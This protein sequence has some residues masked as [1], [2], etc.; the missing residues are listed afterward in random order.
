MSKEQ[1]S[2]HVKPTG[3]ERNFP[4]KGSTVLDRSTATEDRVASRQEAVEAVLGVLRAALD[5]LDADELTEIAGN[6]ERNLRQEPAA[7][8]AEFA[9]EL[10]AGEFNLHDRI[11]LE[12]DA[13]LRYFEHRHHL[14]QDA[15][16]SDQVK[17]ILGTTR[18]TPYDR[19][20]AGSLF[21]IKDRGAYRFPRWQFDAEEHDGLVP[22]VPEVS[23]ALRVSPLAKISWM[24]RPNAF[25]DNATP[26]EC[27]R[28]GQTERVL[29]LARA[30]ERS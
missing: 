21:A 6:L 15:L 1:Q 26:L 17:V 8:T 5:A 9:Q 16:S 22:G 30:V 11:A 25:L 7:K 23:R 12:Q 3:K 18:Q 2:S 20:K 28:T 14:V 10:G 4:V 29:S 24:V 13:L 19:A 27:L